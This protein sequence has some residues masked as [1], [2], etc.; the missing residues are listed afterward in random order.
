MRHRTVSDRSIFRYIVS[1]VPIAEPSDTVAHAIRRLRQHSFAYPDRVYVLEEA[2]RLGGIVEMRDLLAAD[3]E[4]Q[5]K[6]LMRGPRVTVTT[7]ADQ[8]AVLHMARHHHLTAM[9]VVGADGRFIGCV[10]AR[11]LL[12]ISRHEH[13]EDI[14]RLAGIVHSVGRA[15]AALE[16]SPFQRARDRLPWLLVGLLGSIAVTAVMSQFDEVIAADLAIVFFIPAIVYLTDAIGTQTE[17]A[18][19]RGLPISQRPLASLLAG[20]LCT[21]ALIG[22]SLGGMA[23]ALVYLAFGDLRLALG[24]GVALLIAGSA[25]SLCGLL[26][27]WFLQRAGSDPAFGSG[28][29]A[30]VIQDFLTLL[31]YFAAMM[32][33]RPSGPLPEHFL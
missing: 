16:T 28:P 31:I 10:P 14:S 33:L 12:E 13:H 18:A 26:L 17:A 2:H 1:D 23:T 32:L 3:D 19:V 30:T 6:E 27:P 22:G 9:Q 8:E 24:V 25:A 21:G 15:T 4:R 7:E 5:L 20:E 11:A 29:V